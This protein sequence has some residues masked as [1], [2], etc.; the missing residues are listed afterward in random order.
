MSGASAYYLGSVVAYHNDIK[1]NIL[2]V[3]K[4][5]LDSVGA[6]SPETA[7]EMANGV[8]NRFN[9][10]YALSVTGIAGPTGA[11]KDKKVGLVYI[12]LKANHEEAMVFKYEFPLNR[13][14]FR[15]FAANIALFHLYQKLMQDNL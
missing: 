3:K 14:V 5:T 7:A 6:V 12:G 9:T 10:N 15:D 2:G 8:Q 11:T 1:Q 13:D 4:T